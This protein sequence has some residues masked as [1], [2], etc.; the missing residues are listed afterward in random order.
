MDEWAD[1]TTAD[2]PDGERFVPEGLIR[3]KV[4]ETI[5]GDILVSELVSPEGHPVYPTLIGV[6]SKSVENDEGT[7]IIGIVH[8]ATPEAVAQ[9]AAIYADKVARGAGMIRRNLLESGFYPIII[10]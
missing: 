1:L 7:D 3:L 6:E 10:P 4:R 9:S 5:N 2:V 8:W